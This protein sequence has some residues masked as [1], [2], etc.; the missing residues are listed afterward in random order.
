MLS[1]SRAPELCKVRDQHA[2]V[3]K[4]SDELRLKPGDVISVTGKEDDG[5]WHGIAPDGAV[6]VFPSNFVKEL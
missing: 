2:Y 4:S 1:P 3:P 5:W 6:G